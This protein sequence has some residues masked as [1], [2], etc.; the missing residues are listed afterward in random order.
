MNIAGIKGAKGIANLSGGVQGGHIH[1]PN[2]RTHCPEC[3][4]KRM[5]GMKLPP[6]HM[7]GH[8]A[9]EMNQLQGDVDDHS[10]SELDGVDQLPQ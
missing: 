4:T 5:G 7:Q 3:G 2:A 6:P 10:Q 1:A 8:N 9:T